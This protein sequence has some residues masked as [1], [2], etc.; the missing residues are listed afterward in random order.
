MCFFIKHD[1]DVIAAAF[2][3]K[4][5]RICCADSQLLLATVASVIDN[6]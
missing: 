2:L 6:D 4:Q 5:A 1:T 3:T